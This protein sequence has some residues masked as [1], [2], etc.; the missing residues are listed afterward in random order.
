MIDMVVLL[1]P[2]ALWGAPQGGARGAGVHGSAAG[3]LHPAAGAA[4]G[5][6]DP[7]SLYGRR[8]SILASAEPF[9]EG[10]VETGKRWGVD[11]FL[12]V[13]WLA[14][15]ASGSAQIHRRLALC[16]ARHSASAWE[17]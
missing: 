1:T 5:R 3:A 9:S 16:P 4:A 14:P 17:H 13:Q 2:L 7:G 11:E 6:G 12:L 8:R 15:L 10:L